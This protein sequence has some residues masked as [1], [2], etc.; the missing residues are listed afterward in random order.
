MTFLSL[1]QIFLA[2]FLMGI[3]FFDVR[4]GTSPFV[5]MRNEFP[6]APVFQDPQYLF[7]YLTDGNGLNVLLQNYW[8]VIH[9]PVLF[10]GF[11]STISS[12]FFCCRG[13]MEKRSQR[14]DPA[15]L[16]LVSIQ[17]RHPWIGNYDG[18]GLGI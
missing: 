15:G 1:A 9:P 3:Y 5:L 7:K 8:M 4:I 11:A 10:L 14:L 18:C 12:I 2:S 17:R 6:D 13:L 16:T